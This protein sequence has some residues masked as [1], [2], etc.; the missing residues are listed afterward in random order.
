M[1][2]RQ[3]NCNY[4]VL[5][6][7]RCDRRT[8]ICSRCAEKNIA[9]SYSSYSSFGRTRTARQ[10]R[11]SLTDD[12]FEVQTAI[13]G[14]AQ[15]GVTSVSGPTQ[16][17]RSRPPGLSCSRHP[18]AA[19]AHSGSTAVM[20]A[21]VD[22]DGGMYTNTNTNTDMEAFADF[23]EDA[24]DTSLVADICDQWLMPIDDEQQQPH[25]ERP[26]SPADEDIMRSYQNLAG[27]CVSSI[28]LRILLVTPPCIDL[29]LT[30]PFQKQV[31]P[32]HI[33]DPKTPIHFV[34]GR[35][36]ALTADIATRNA[37]PF[38]HRFLYRD[39]MPSCILRCFTINALYANRKNAHTP[40]VMRAIHDGARELLLDVGADTDADNGIVK[41]MQKLARTQALFLYQVIRLLDG[42]VTLRAQGER[43]IQILRMW[44]GELCKLRENL[45][46][47]VQLGDGMIRKQP[48]IEWEVSYSMGCF[49][50][51]VSCSLIYVCQAW[52]FAESVRRTIVLAYSFMH[53]YDMMK[54]FDDTGSGLFFPVTS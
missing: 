3:K 4:C 9:C 36:Q 46:D 19:E 45:G 49:R 8:P 33:H 30:N 40:M 31:Q 22:N 25:S 26:P 47:M 28:H 32:W 23:M 21:P 1:R 18:R 7:R 35:L 12:D 50:N 14:T 53:L 42:D 15:A 13:L 24:V 34:I 48:P 20:D 16:S 52:I 10:Q 39:Y 27:I 29:I 43:D 5:I 41:P 51:T 6:K 37:A 11:H 44:V 38:L 17:A 54:G 2:S